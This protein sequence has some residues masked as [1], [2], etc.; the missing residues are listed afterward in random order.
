MTS[1]ASAQK[2]KGKGWFDKTVA[3]IHLWP[4]L[5]SALIVIFVCLTG[6][7]IVY[8]DEIMDVT[9]GDAR[10]VREVKQTQLSTDRLISI[11]KEELPNRDNPG[12]AVYY[13]DPRRS[14]RFNSYE[15]DA[16]LR[17]VYIDQYTGEI[18]KDSPVIHFF[19]ITAHLHNS[20]L[21][22]TPGQWIIDIATIIFLIE[23]ITGLILWWPRR[24]TKATRD[25]SFRIKWKAKFKRLN[26]DLH[27]VFG[28]YALSICM[29]LTVTGLIIAFHPLQEW[30][31]SAFGGDPEHEWMDS[32]ST[33]HQADP[34]SAELVI[35]NLFTQ[36]PDKKE[37]Q[38][39]TFDLEAEGHYMI[40]LG[41]SIGLK[42][43]ESQ[44][45]LAIDKYNGKE[46]TLTNAQL[47]HMKVENVYW[48]LHMGKWMGPIGKLLTFLGGLI[49]TSLPV[50]GFLIWWGRRKKKKREPQK[51]K[52]RAIKYGRNFTALIIVLLPMLCNA[53]QPRE[54]KGRVLTTDGALAYVTVLLLDDKHIQL[55]G[56]I[57]DSTGYF[58]LKQ[59]TADNC[60]LKIE[61][62]GYLT[63]SEPIS[64]YGKGSVYDAGSILLT[65]DQQMLETV[66]VTGKKPLFQQKAD[67]LTMNIEQSILADG[68]NA[69][70][71]LEKAPGVYVDQDG[72]ISLRGKQ[73][74]NVMINGKL[75]YLSARELGN[76]LK[77]TSSTS[78]STIDI[79]T[80]P[81]AKYDAAGVAGIID[82]RL[83]RNTR[84]G[85]N[86]TVYAN[87]GRGRANRY[88][89]GFNLNYANDKINLFSNYDH[90]YRGESETF[91]FIRNFYDEE[92]MRL[93]RTSIQEATTD[94]PLRG[95]NAKI[96]GI[97]N[98]TSKSVLGT[99]IGMN[100][101][102]Y[103][104][105]NIS[106]NI[107]RA[108][109]G[110]VISDA[111]TDNRNED[112]WKSLSANI[113]FVHSFDE[114]G[115]Q[116]AVDVDHNNSA[117]KANQGL[118]TI[119]RPLPGQTTD[120][121]SSR[122]AAIDANTKVYV[123]KADYTHPLG[124]HTKI[125]GGSKASWVTS[126]NAVA[127]D[128]L[129]NN[130]W[131]PDYSTSNHFV[132]KEQIYAVYAN[133]QHNINRFEIQAG[134]RTENTVT[135]GHQITTDSLVKRNYI[136][137][138]PSLFV[139]YDLR[140]NNYLQFSYG[141]RIERPDYYDLNPFRFFRD[142]SVYY[143]GNPF[144]QPETTHALDLTFSHNNIL[145]ATLFF[146]NTDNVM[147]DII[148]QIDGSNTTVLRP[149]NLKKLNNYGLTL[150]STFNINTWWSAN[151][152]VNVY[153]NEYT[154]YHSGQD[155][156]MN[157]LSCSINSQ[158]SL[159]LGS[160][161]QGEVN[162]EYHSSMVYGLFVRKPNYF[163]SAGI[164]KRIAHEKITLK[165]NVNDIFK[166]ASFRQVIDYGNIDMNQKIN[167]DSRI[168]TFS[169]SYRFGNSV[170]K[171]V[172]QKEN[173]IQKRVKGAG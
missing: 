74:V 100:Q 140:K 131:M 42:S 164:Q 78:I 51:D 166:T 34:I 168:I 50:T 54:V 80:N 162:A 124:T 106:D 97:Y 137:L 139:K 2:K 149:Q 68:N 62:M 89:S 133:I 21:L 111:A 25:A 36:Y 10:Y 98:L 150:S 69:L 92:R 123:L 5:I 85:T 154:G 11:I 167:L 60:T 142:P 143:E 86:G 88:G 49:A 77:T 17:M 101:G 156:K 93:D 72:N 27:N 122:R 75:T 57:T 56:T 23:L 125:E 136:Q 12:Y 126:D 55:K 127:Y 64:L 119:F 121:R 102:T 91:S 114:D 103:K 13:R 83:K 76:M 135:S 144:L 99:S 28:F 82:V 104:N 132:Y 59:I 158:N 16:G 53:Q 47:M 39:S 145:M 151:N 9:A 129:Q 118:N 109:D 31:V 148:T 1:N 141:R 159:K 161:L 66:H 33:L 8:C 40:N 22:H 48:N 32:I 38:L 14:V 71:I 113:N 160:N 120:L 147:T 43:V 15:K 95:N 29:V 134:I 130:S 3:W 81:S 169:V 61:H 24:W 37:A 18:L 7:I 116:L 4:S 117:F 45:P 19:Y 20:L 153:V 63:L 107:L 44:L 172:E 110:T 52:P 152:F 138:F 171:Q 115:R 79:I 94:E 35:K 105:I 112:E 157:R 90:S 87:Y 165:L 58:S 6:T 108:S 26:Y 65:P 96:G 173:D 70:E 170:R 163:V 41:K 73:G 30:T 46:I 155:F 67:R 84:S 146:K 128:T